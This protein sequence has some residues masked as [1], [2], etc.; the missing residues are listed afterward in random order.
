MKMGLGVSIGIELLLDAEF[1]VENGNGVNVA[2]NTQLV[3]FELGLV[4]VG[5]GTT[6]AIVV[7]TSCVT[8]G[9]GL[10]T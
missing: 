9:P 10:M 1:D 8:V 7:V 4:S 6:L 5:A 2:D 3:L